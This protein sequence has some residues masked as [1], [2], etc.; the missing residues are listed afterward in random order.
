MSTRGNRFAPGGYQAPATNSVQLT[1]GKPVRERRWTLGPVTAELKIVPLN[2]GRPELFELALLLNDVERKHSDYMPCML[3][4]L[5][6]AKQAFALTAGELDA[7]RLPDRILLPP[8][9]PVGW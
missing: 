3:R 1:R 5:E 8:G 2:G 4:G 9:A 7:G 6:L